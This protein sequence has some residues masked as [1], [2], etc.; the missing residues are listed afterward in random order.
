MPGEERKHVA[1]IAHAKRMTSKRGS[2]PVGEFEEGAK[3]LLVFLRG[4]F[5]GFSQS[6]DAD[7]F[8]RA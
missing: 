1:F 5:D 8:V 4:F 2:W 6:L 3:I 7:G